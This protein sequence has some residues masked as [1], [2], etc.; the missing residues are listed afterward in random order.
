MYISFKL[1]AARGRD[2]LEALVSLA[3]TRAED[4]SHIKGDYSLSEVL[5]GDKRV[6]SGKIDLARTP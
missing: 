4:V 3:F 5:E 1:P 2:K 6:L